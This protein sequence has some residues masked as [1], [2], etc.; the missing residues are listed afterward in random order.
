MEAVKI[1]RDPEGF[2]L[3]DDDKGR[4]QDLLLLRDWKEEDEDE[5]KENVKEEV[6]TEE[7]RGKR[8]YKDTSQDGLQGTFKDA[9][10]IDHIFDVQWT[11]C[12]TNDAAFF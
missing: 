11:Y 4:E 8:K 1:K 9:L 10:F 3:E 2:V 12:D 6:K 7:Q 5:D